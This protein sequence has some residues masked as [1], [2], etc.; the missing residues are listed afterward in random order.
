MTMN[1]DIDD[2][3]KFMYGTTV[4]LEYL[5]K[6]SDEIKADVKILRDDVILL[7][8]KAVLLGAVAGFIVTLITKFLI[9]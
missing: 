4:H 2:L 5:T 7:K 3:K 6:T 9:H 1:N 8:A